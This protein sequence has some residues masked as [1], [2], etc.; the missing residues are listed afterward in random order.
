LQVH[1]PICNTSLAVP[2]LT[3]AAFA[4]VAAV[5][6]AVLLQDVQLVMFTTVEL[7][8]GVLLPYE[9]SD[10]AA[11]GIEEISKTSAFCCI[12]RIF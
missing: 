10:S 8:H 4:V 1:S 3:T 5:V 2:C 6:A 9:T 7:A 12:G 11:T